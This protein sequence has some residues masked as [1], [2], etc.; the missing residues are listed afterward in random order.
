MN[1]KNLKTFYVKHK[2]KILTVLR[3]AISLGLIAYLIFFSSE[4]KDFNDFVDILKTINVPLL[5]ASASL[6]IFGIWISSLRWQILLKTQQINISILFLI[7]SFLI[8]SFFNNILP[9]SIGGDVF[10]SIDVANRA[11]VSVGKSATIVVVDRFTGVL[12]AAVYAVI[13]LLLGFTRVGSTSYIIPVVA[14][15]AVCILL[16]F[17]ILNPSILRLERL[18]EKIKFL[19]KIRENLKEVYHTFQ[20]FKQYKPALFKA[21]LCSFA[22]QLAVIASYYL[23]SRALGINLSFASFIFIVP[24]VSFIS[25]LPISIGGMGV[26]ENSIVFLM[27][28]L[29]AP[30][31][32]SAMTSLIIF[33]IILAIGLTGAIV[34]IVRPFVSKQPNTTSADVMSE[35][36]TDN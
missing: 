21:M 10:R 9:T 13:A 23:A 17:L 7:S 29:G 3:I 28:A 25:M 24:I 18:V 15:F 1:L 35:K 16:G 32:L 20:S 5:L 12:T 2:K 6:H 33:A 8:G 14:F 11:K 4:F 30:R 19:K 22:L 31:D 36:K 26:R 27:A 34:Y